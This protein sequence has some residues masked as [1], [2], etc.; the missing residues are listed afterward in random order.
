VNILSRSGDQLITATQAKDHSKVTT[1][2]EDQLW[3][4]W[5][6]VA[7][8]VAERETNLIF[9][10]AEVEQV[11]DMCSIDLH[12]PVRSIVS[13][14][15]YDSDGA[16]TVLV[17]G[18]GYKVTRTSAFGLTVDL[19]STPVNYAVVRYKAG[20]GAFTTSSGEYEVTAG[21]IDAPEIAK[22]LI[23]LLTDHFYKNRSVLSDMNKI[24]L[25]YG[26]DRVCQ[27]IKKEL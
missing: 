3:L 7:H 11:F 21:T 2:A 20:Y 5:V 18:E 14:T 1:T 8:E 16:A 25:P 23:Y 9:Q 22:Q 6:N 10:Q 12:A 19:V 24:E 4:L 27:L 15:T 17:Q 13:V 26:F